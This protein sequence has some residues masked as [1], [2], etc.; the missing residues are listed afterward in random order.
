MIIFEKFIVQNLLNIYIELADH[1]IKIIM[2]PPT[3]I[4]TIINNTE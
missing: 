4:E 1:P 2:Y 3:V